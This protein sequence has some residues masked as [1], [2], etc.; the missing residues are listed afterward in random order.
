LAEHLHLPVGEM[1]RRMDSR[2]LTEWQAFF[3]L[4]QE[5]Q[6]PPPQSAADKLR[7]MFGHRIQKKS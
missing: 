1:L 7:A 6:Q 4:R 3:K 5:R 2:E